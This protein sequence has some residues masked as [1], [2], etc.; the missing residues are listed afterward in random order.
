M[1][2]QILE[3]CKV[4]RVVEVSDNV[5]YNFLNSRSLDGDEFVRCIQEVFLKYYLYNSTRGRTILDLA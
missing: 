3:R 4:N 2:R 5:N 1:C